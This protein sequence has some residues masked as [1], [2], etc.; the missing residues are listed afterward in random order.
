MDFEQATL[1]TGQE[2][3]PKYWQLQ[4]TL[5]VVGLQVG[6]TV[7]DTHSGGPATLEQFKNQ[8]LPSTVMLGAVSTTRPASMGSSKDC[9]PSLYRGSGALLLSTQVRLLRR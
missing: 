8:L 6:V 9:C 4:G 3:Q 7:T 5:V 2:L 1:R